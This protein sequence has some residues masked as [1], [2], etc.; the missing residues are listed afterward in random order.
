MRES[1][2]GLRVLSSLAPRLLCPSPGCIGIRAHGSE[3][4]TLGSKY[5][6]RLIVMS[7]RH[8]FAALLLGAIATSLVGCNSGGT[9]ATSPIDLSPPQAPTNLHSST[10]ANI[11]R[12]WLVWDPS[13]S[14]NVSGYEIY[15][16]PSVGGTGQLITT[17]DASTSD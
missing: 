4:L 1:W 10:D 14:A 16:A 17:V 7:R 5:N 2:A 6:C 15:S 12:D 8:L 13:A 11:S 9:S 3:A